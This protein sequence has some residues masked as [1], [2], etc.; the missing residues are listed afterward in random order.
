M[1][2]QGESRTVTVGIVYPAEWDA[3]DPAAATDGMAALEALDPR[4][5]VVECRYAESTELRSARGAGPP[6]DALREQAP[7]LTD[8]QRARFAEI[9]VALAMD[10]PFDVATV[11]PRLRW[12]Q[13]IGAGVNQL[14]SSG[15]AE[16]G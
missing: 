8:E 1:A 11:A 3:A 6:Y 9:E 7:A 16:S 12:V 15:L 10:L 2:G 5:R 13:G 4:V 14:L